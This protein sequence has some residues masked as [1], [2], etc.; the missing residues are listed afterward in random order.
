MSVRRSP[1]GG[2]E[3]VDVAEIIRFNCFGCVFVSVK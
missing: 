2:L 1:C 3:H